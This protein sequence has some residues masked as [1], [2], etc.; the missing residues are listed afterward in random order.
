MVSFWIKGGQPEAFKFFEKLKVFLL[1]VSLGGVESFAE[2]PLTMTHENVPAE[3]RELLEINESL[4]R[5]SCGIEDPADLIE[6]LR[7]AL[8]F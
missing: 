8:E 3:Q 2:Y 1:A 6:D 7:Q 4:I 5:L